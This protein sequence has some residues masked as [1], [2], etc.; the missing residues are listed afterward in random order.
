VVALLAWLLLAPPASAATSA[1]PA[2]RELLAAL[3]SRDSARTQWVHAR[4]RG[5]LASL[6]AAQQRLDRA[7]D[8]YGT[9]LDQSVLPSAIAARDRN[10]WSKIAM[11]L[12]ERGSWTRALALLRG[13]LGS[14]AIL[15]PVEA[16]AAGRVESP[17]AALGILGFAP[18][19]APHDLDEA[20]LY[21]ASAISDSA[22]LARSS[23]AARWLLLVDSRRPATARSWG[24]SYCHPD[25]LGLNKRILLWGVGGV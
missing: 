3:A 15:L 24:Q 22:G 20:A 16:L 17:A 13:P 14:P 9:L 1:R 2:G 8:R 25:G 12:A 4:W 10:A 19:R 11:E 23:R 6:R 18:S 7:S 21:V 5:S